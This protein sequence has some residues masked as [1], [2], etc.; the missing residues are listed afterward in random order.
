MSY[1]FIS[2][3]IKYN[4]RR[5]IRF[6]YHLPILFLN[7]EN[8]LYPLYP[9]NYNYYIIFIKFIYILNVMSNVYIN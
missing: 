6:N 3:F 8:P 5:R 1:L 4:D 7:L 2:F 9:Y